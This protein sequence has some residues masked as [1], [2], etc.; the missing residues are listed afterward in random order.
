MIEQIQQKIQLSKLT[1]KD[2]D[3]F[4]FTLICDIL[5]FDLYNKMINFLQ[6]FQQIQ[7]Q[8]LKSNVLDLLFKYFRKFAFA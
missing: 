8:Y 2:I 1:F 7:H 4:D 6:N 3:I 5:K